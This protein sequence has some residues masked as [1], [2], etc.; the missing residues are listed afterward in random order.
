MAKFSSA[1]KLLWGTFYAG[2]YFTYGYGVCNDVFNN[3]FITGYTNCTK[4]IVTSGPYQTLATGTNDAYLA[5][6]TSAGS[7]SWATFY[8]GDNEN[9]GF[10]LS[11]DQNG[12]IYLTGYTT[13]KNGIATANAFQ[14]S[15]GGAGTD[16]TGDAFLAKFSNSGNLLWGT[17]YGGSND[18]KGLAVSTDNSDNIYLTGKTRSSN[19]IST[20]GAYQTSL[21]NNNYA[22]FLAKFSSTGKRL[23]ASYYGSGYGE[24]GISNSGKVCADNFGNVYVT[25]STASLSNNLG[26][27]SGAFQ[28]S[29]GYGNQDAF[30]AKFSFKIKYD[31]GI[32][33]IIS[34]NGN[35]CVNAEDVTLKLINY[36]EVELDSVKI[37]WTIN[38]KPQKPYNWYGKLQPD[39]NTYINAGTYFFKPGID[40]IK[41]WTFLPNGFK[42]SIPANDTFRVID[43]VYALPKPM[44]G[45]NH[46]I[47]NGD[48]VQLG[49]NLIKGH[50]YFWASRPFGFNSTQSNPTVKPN[51]TTTYYLI[52][53]V[54]A[55]GCNNIDS[56]IITV[57]PLPK[58]SAGGNQNI[59]P[60]KI[61]NLGTAPINGHS[62]AWTSKPTGFS[63]TLSNPSV[64]ATST[65]TYYLRETILTTGCSAIDSAI[66]S[67][68]PLPNLLTS[69]HDTIC[70]GSS[71]SI[72]TVP[73]NGYLYS[74][75]SKPTGFNSNVAHPLVKPVLNSIYYLTQTIT[76]TG[77]SLL[78]SVTVTINPL[79][80]PI[81][82][83]DKNI[84]PGQKTS[85]GYAGTG[86]D[87][88]KWTTNPAGYTATTSI[89]TD[90]PTFSRRYILTETDPTTGCSNKDSTF[91]FV[92]PLPQP[93]I[94]GIDIICAV[95]TPITFYTPFDSLATW[96]WFVKA[97]TL[98]T[99]QGTHKITVK[100]Y[101]GFD[102]IAVSET[103]AA[104]CTAIATKTIGIRRSSDAHFKILSDSPAYIFKANGFTQQNYY[105][106]LGDGDSSNLVEVTHVYDFKKDTFIKVSLT[107]INAFGC[108]ITFDTVIFIKY[109]P[110]PVFNIKVF[111]NPFENATHIRIELEKSAHIRIMVYDAIGRRITTLTDADQSP[112]QQTYTLDGDKY[113]L[114]QAVY[115]LKIMVDDKVY[116]RKVLRQ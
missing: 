98:L 101:P 83:K 74:W 21:A 76:S 46:I 88:Y 39:S 9:R 60:G 51:F 78:D 92:N 59:C 64:T 47:C 70:A 48:S 24:Y 81:A 87:N 38:S 63:S 57:N 61:L 114:S 49:A 13:S 82:G 86:K 34:P 41:A 23:W 20:A 90:S 89:I 18:E 105:W 54:S 79:P 6:F 109:F 110:P 113:A 36:G 29:Y 33:S 8:G 84:Y 17:Y 14:T 40:T 77:C 2:N 97:G 53:K 96:H 44:T 99:G 106:K 42:D 111:P 75:T 71:I 112:G 7:L 67:V 115:L 68:I 35:F 11:A 27:T 104:G 108:A 69:H 5:K 62:Y 16:N 52:E 103:N 72:G 32:K 93:V 3:V 26:I 45:G 85:L 65:K 28:T 116:V 100:L 107:I 25:G 66:V 30:L 31:A 43:T 4:G 58:P 73:I 22:A 102:S 95:D 10:G 50:T 37:N 91:I 12:N 1:G 55:T 80:K 94:H 15:F 56:V 19:G